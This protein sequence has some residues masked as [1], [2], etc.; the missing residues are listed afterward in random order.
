MAGALGARLR[1]MDTIFGTQFVYPPEEKC[2]GILVNGQG[3]RFVNEASYGAVIGWNIIHEEEGT[4]WLILDSA[5]AEEVEAN[6]GDVS[7][8]FASAETIEELAELLGVPG[9]VLAA[10]LATY[11][12][13]AVDGTDPL[14]H[15][16][17]RFVTP[18][19]SGPYLAFDLGQTGYLSFLTTGHVEIDM[20]ARVLDQEGN[21]IPGLYAAGQNGAGIGR[22]QYNSG[23]RLGEGSFFGRVAGKTAAAA[24]PWTGDTETIHITNTTAYFAIPPASASATPQA[25]V[26]ESDIRVTVEAVD[27]AFT[28]SEL[29]I[30]A[31]TDVT[32]ELINNGLA[33]HDLAIEDTE[34]KTPLVDGGESA[35][36]TV[37]LPAGEYTY[38]CTVPGHRQ[39]GMVG[40]LI[41]Q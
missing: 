6:G 17:E 37:N 24:E 32:I 13:F 3:R 9:Q 12:Q 34:Y 4:A 40:T 1:D 36:V 5:V 10:E 14:F 20:Q 41:V 18:L 15:K 33:P 21:V 16:E 26:A 2:K 35:T 19:E 7:S 11:N 28:E 25:E 39:S 30:P 8:P 22:R 27:I 38:Y 31:D 23:V 29:T